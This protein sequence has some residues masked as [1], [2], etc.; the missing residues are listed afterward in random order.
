MRVLVVTNPR[1]TA[2]SDRER[3][4]LAHALA[5]DAELEV[6]ETANRGHAAAL[7][8]RAMRNGTDVVVALGGDG[9]VNEVING[10]LTDG[11][12]DGVPA[13]GVV[14]AGSTNVFVRAL[15]L[16]NDPIEA[17]GSLLE[18]LRSGSRRSV[19]MGMADDRY[20]CFAAGLGFDA[21]IVHGVE[22]KRRQGKRS[23]HVLYSRVGVSEFFRADRRHPKLHVEL[24]DGTRIEDVFFAVVTNAD[25]WTYVGNRPLRPTPD[26]DFDTGLGL[27]ARRRMRTLGV[28]VS[29][30]RLSGKRPRIGRF[31]ARVVQDLDHITVVAD[32]PMPF[33]V[34]GDALDS[35]EKVTFRA[36]PDAIR[37]VVAPP[38]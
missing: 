16:P 28:L 32:E 30:A 11:V 4:V 17:T 38:G 2:M 9:T 10:L 15:G 18:G 35:R 3:D 13:L 27:Y 29:M 22:R 21:A 5:S 1:A 14:P 6:A 19:S 23:T 20:F 8:C 26:V 33:Q 37:V 7:A 34:D 31:G 25:P 24:A 12:H 36:V